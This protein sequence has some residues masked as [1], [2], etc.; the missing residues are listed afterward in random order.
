[1]PTASLLEPEPEPDERL[2]GDTTRQADLLRSCPRLT[3]CR[4]VVDRGI[5]PTSR[6]ARGSADPGDGPCP[7]L[8]APLD[9][10]LAGVIGVG[11]ALVP[12]AVLV[13]VLGAGLTMVLARMDAPRGGGVTYF[14]AG[15]AFLSLSSE[16]ARAS[17]AALDNGVEMLVVGTLVGA[18][19]GGEGDAF[20]SMLVDVPGGRAVPGAGGRSVSTDKIGIGGGGPM[21]PLPG[22]FGVS[23]TVVVVSVSSNTPRVGVFAGWGGNGGGSSCTGVGAIDDATERDEERS[24]FHAQ[25]LT[26]SSTSLPAASRRESRTRFRP[27]HASATPS[28]PGP[29]ALSSLIVSIQC[30]IALPIVSMARRMSAIWRSASSIDLIDMLLP[31]DGR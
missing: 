29:P 24:S 25:S 7:G 12:A 22:C 9:L 18:L 27:V 11:A 30:D 20:R 4:A 1:M 2:V 26:I 28:P 10:V 17:A 8:G 16:T 15:A 23:C 14:A 6:P 5:E 21:R 3:L 19:A 13:A 31:D